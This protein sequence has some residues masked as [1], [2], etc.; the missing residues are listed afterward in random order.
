M[1]VQSQKSKIC[2]IFLPFFHLLSQ[3]L[4]DVNNIVVNPPQRLLIISGSEPGGIISGVHQL[5]L[6]LPHLHTRQNK[7]NYSMKLVR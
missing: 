2:T 7:Q 5:G 1:W 3:Q 6:P 4:E